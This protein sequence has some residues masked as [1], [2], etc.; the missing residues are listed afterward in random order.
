MG[1]GSATAKISGI[2]GFSPN[3]KAPASQPK[4]PISATAE[5]SSRSLRGAIARQTDVS[6][7]CN[8]SL[9]CHD[10]SLLL[11]AMSAAM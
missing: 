6:R 1:N 3:K 10:Q 2:G 4:V 9:T 11:R 7:L 8:R 5:S